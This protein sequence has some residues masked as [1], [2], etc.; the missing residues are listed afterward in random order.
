M[1]TNTQFTKIMQSSLFRLDG[2]ALNLLK[3]IQT[4][5]DCINTDPLET[6]WD[7]GECL[8][9][10]LSDFIV[11]AYWALTECHSG[12]YSESYAVMCSL[13]SIF[14]PGMACGPDEDAGEYIAYEMICAE[15]STGVRG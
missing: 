4:L 9:C 5:C 15:L 2:K 11:G 7:L 14:S 10:C 8:D 3:E 6:D 13:G 1:T 12:Q